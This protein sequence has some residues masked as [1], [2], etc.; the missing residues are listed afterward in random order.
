LGPFFVRS[1]ILKDEYFGAISRPPVAA[2]TPP[3]GRSESDLYATKPEYGR[4]ILCFLESMCD[5]PQVLFAPIMPGP[6][7]TKKP[8]KLSGF[9]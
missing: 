8:L 7:K 1:C 6:I 3:V 9:C 4:A 2:K 5:D